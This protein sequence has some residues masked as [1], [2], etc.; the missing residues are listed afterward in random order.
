MKGDV[1]GMSAGVAYVLDMTGKFTGRCNTEMVE[2]Q[3]LDDPDEIEALRIIIQ[4]HRQKTRSWRAAQLLSEWTRMQRA[5]WR[6]APP[7]T[8][9]SACDYVDN[10][11]SYHL[12]EGFA[13]LPQR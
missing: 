8:I 10:S 13:A 4:W 1:L 6:V 12:P 3:R 7:G 2:L 9:H 5:F 11:S